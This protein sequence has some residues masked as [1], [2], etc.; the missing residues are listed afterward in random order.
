MRKNSISIQQPG[1]LFLV[2]YRLFW[3][4]VGIIKGAGVYVAIDTGVGPVGGWLGGG[5]V[6]KED[7]SLRILHVAV[8]IVVLSTLL[9]PVL[10][11]AC[12]H[13]LC[14]GSHLA[15]YWVVAVKA[16]LFLLTLYYILLSIS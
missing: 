9:V 3:R 8:A 11:L 12:S 1:D 4:F 10:V 15:I 13:A 16:W 7:I 5:F 2:L 6:L 14:R